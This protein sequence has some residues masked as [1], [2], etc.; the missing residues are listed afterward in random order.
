MGLLINIF[1]LIII[2]TVDFTNLATYGYIAVCIFQKAHSLFLYIWSVFP[3]L[4]LK[5]SNLSYG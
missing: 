1:Y 3:T 5:R 2:L 4:I